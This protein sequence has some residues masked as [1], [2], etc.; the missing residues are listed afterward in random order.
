MGTVCVEIA[1][2]DDPRLLDA[3]GSLAD[4]T[5]RP[6]R[7]LLAASPS[8]PQALLDAACRRA[9]TLSIAVGRYP[10]GIVGAR[11]ASLAEIPEELTAFLDSDEVAPP[12]WLG[13]LIA[14]LEQGR[15]EFSGG[16][17]RPRRP[18]ETPIERYLEELE[19][20]IYEGLVPTQVVY[21]P[22]QNTAWRTPE[23]KRLGFDPRIPYA[24]DHDLESR[25]LSAGLR[26][27]YVPEA[28][29]FHDKSLETSYGRWLR[30]RYRYLVAMAMSLIKNGSLRHRLGE[31]RSPVRHPLRFLE[32]PLKPLALVH[33]ALRWRSVR[34]HPR[35]PPSG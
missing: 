12:E 5:R 24:E 20:S 33:G 34:R 6:D 23:L 9:P 31:H 22:L 17:T 28:W 13:R 16:P 3:V 35:P 21:L 18:A 25:A 10:G 14:P 7:V 4:Q 11:A 8:T 26:G 15:A 19:R 30:K 32:A 27:V 1:V 2:G 29:V